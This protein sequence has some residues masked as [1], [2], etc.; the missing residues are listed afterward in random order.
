M[1]DRATVDASLVVVGYADDPAGT[2]KYVVCEIDSNANLDRNEISDT[3]KC[4]VLKEL[5]P[6]NVTFSGN[7]VIVTDQDSD[8]ASNTELLALWA[9]KTKKYWTFS[10]STDETEFFVGGYGWLKTY[11]PSAASE[12]TL[13]A[14]FTITIDG[15][16]DT[17]PAS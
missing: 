15:D 2:F 14:A 5:G 12:G 4:G 11:N 7:M 1:A 13:K 10:Q 6:Q 17:E 16:I 8:E 3:T 9:A